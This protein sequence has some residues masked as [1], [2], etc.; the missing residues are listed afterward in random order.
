MWEIKQDGRK[1]LFNIIRLENASRK[2]YLIMH[3]SPEQI[4]LVHAICSGLNTDHIMSDAG[5]L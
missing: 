5:A 1:I 3:S 4:V 2:I